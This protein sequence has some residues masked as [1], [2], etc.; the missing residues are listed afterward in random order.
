MLLPLLLLSVE[1]GL[2]FTV[3][4]ITRLRG[5]Q[6]VRCTVRCPLDGTVAHVELLDVH[7][8]AQPVNLVR[9]SRLAR[10]AV[11]SCDRACLRR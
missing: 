6:P 2:L 11:G 3:W 8:T 5:E 4:L 1:A 10:G 9:C 7:G